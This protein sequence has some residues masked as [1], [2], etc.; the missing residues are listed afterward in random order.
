MRGSEKGNGGWHG[1][2]CCGRRAHRLLDA[3]VAS[4]NG[5]FP[6][7]LSFV[8]EPVYPVRDVRLD[9]GLLVLGG[10][11]WLERFMLCEWREW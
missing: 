4:S 5:S 1:G 6:T 8:K 2:E 9:V 11:H 3:R 7:A 10:Q